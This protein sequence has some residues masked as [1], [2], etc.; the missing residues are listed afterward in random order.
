MIGDK[1]LDMPVTVGDCKKIFEE[2]GLK[3]VHVSEYAFFPN[4]QRFVYLNNE[5]YSHFNNPEFL[6]NRIDFINTIRKI[7]A[8]MSNKEGE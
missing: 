7:E 1:R 5:V 3:N 2:F 6:Q 8:P 4:V